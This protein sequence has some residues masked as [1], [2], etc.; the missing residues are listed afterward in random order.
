MVDMSTFPSIGYIAVGQQC[1]EVGL[2]GSELRFFPHGDILH[3][4]L[5]FPE[6]VQS[7]RPETVDEFFDELHEVLEDRPAQH[8]YLR[9]LR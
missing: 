6:F 5:T 4:G 9:R 1:W 7:L 3:P 8:H 2:F